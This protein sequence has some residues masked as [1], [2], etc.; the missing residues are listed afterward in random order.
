MTCLF[1]I[2]LLLVILFTASNIYIYGNTPNRV[3]ADAAIV[4][5]AEVWGREP[6]PVFKERI[7]H[8]VNLYKTRD[9]GKIIFTGGVGTGKE[10]SEAEA[11]KQYA[12]QNGVNQIDILT[13]SKSRTTN[14]NLKYALE[15]AQQ[16]NLS[17]FLIVSD[18]LHMKR[19][20][21]MARN[22]GL[23]A[24]PS[25][26]LTTRYRSVKSQLQF[27]SRETYFYFVYLIFKV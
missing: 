5:G 25:P 16:H 22:L 27:L 3:K 1:L 24:F 6:S 23:D 26:T 2:G 19:A 13:E 12:I 14:Q 21:L 9:V 7:N 11:G 15:V 20:V 8:A 4:L 17:N 10:I 18:P